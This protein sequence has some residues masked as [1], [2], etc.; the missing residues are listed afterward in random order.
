MTKNKVNTAS[1]PFWLNYATFLMTT[2]HEA[3]AARAFLSRA[4]Q[5]VPQIQHRTLT[6]KFGALEFTSPH[7]DPER[8]RTIFEGLLSAYPKRWDLWDMLLDLEKSHGADENVRGLF[9]RMA[10]LKMKR[11]RAMLIFKKWREFEEVNEDKKAA[12]KV[13]AKEAKYMERLAK[14][15]KTRGMTRGSTKALIY[16]GGNAKHICM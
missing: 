2:L 13:K 1:V 11:R 8:G 3:A 15:G 6:A 16:V 7:G 12:E 14:G 5:S 4:T 10:G 9:E